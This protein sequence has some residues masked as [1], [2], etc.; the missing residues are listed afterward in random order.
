M[1]GL[2]FNNS[3]G[4]SDTFVF[5]FFFVCK[6]LNT[7]DLTCYKDFRPYQPSDKKYSIVM[8]IILRCS[9]ACKRNTRPFS[10]QVTV[11]GNRLKLHNACTPLLLMC[12]YR[13]K[14]D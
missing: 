6:L 1:E 8:I 5:F 7:F 4:W 9:W 10:V 14:W 13:A 11:V 2:H 12:A 3:M